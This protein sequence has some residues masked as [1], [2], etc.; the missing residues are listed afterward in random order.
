[1]LYIYCI[2]WYYYCLNGSLGEILTKRRNKIVQ[3]WKKIP[4]LNFET[5]KSTFYLYGDVSQT[6]FPNC[7]DFCDF[8]LKNGV[9]LVPGTEF[10]SNDSESLTNYFRMSFGI[11][12][13][14]IIER[15]AELLTE[16][17][18]NL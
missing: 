1:M 12:S 7:N 8:A 16:A 17:L 13:G 5:P 14:G 18:Y 11:G 2:Y 3:T 6:E 4:G 10:G 9:I 15:G